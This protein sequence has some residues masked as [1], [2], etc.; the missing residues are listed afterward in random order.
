VTARR[1]NG[2]MATVRTTLRVPVLIL[3]KHIT[4]LGV[5]RVLAARAIETYGVD[6]TSDII[7]RSRW[8]RPAERTLPETAD[9]DELAG[10][11]Q[12]LHVPRAVLIACS[13]TWT[14]SVAGCHRRHG[15]DS[16]PAWHRG[17]PWS[18]S[19]IPRV[20]EAGWS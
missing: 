9:S 6:A 16:R 10:F 2:V 8:Y 4:A 12:S 18:S 14:R 7:V 5:L 1:H 19:L 17:R 20:T 15:G 11:L 3:G 13:D